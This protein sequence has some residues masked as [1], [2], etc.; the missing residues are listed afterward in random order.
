MCNLKT[1]HLFES[2]LSNSYKVNNS[3]LMYRAIE[4]NDEPDSANE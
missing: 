1:G 3:L 2:E 4:T